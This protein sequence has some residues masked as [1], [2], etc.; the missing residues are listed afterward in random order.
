MTYPQDD[1]AMPADAGPGPERPGGPGRV[2][3]VLVG[4]LVLLL[5]TGACIWSITSARDTAVR[6]VE[7]RLNLIADGRVE[8]VGAW[9]DGVV[10]AAAR[11]ADSQFLRAYAA[12]RFGDDGDT[13]AGTPDTGGG[14]DADGPPRA[15]DGAAGRGARL[16]D[17]AAYLRNLARDFV[18]RTRFLRLVLVDPTGAPALSDAASLGDIPAA[19]AE[20]AVATAEI[21]FGASRVRD[22]TTI[23][24][25]AYPVVRPQSDRAPDAVVGA[26]LLEIGL[27][28]ILRDATRLPDL[29][30]GTETIRVLEHAGG[31]RRVLTP[32]GH[33]AW[34]VAGVGD[35]RAFA[36]T[37]ATH[38]GTPVFAAG[39]P[40]DGLPWSV[41][42]STTVDRALSDWRRFSW[43]AA[44]VAAGLALAV[45]GGLAGFWYRLSASHARDR[46]AREQAF[47]RRIERERRLLDQITGTVPELIALKAGDGSYRYVNR[48][49]ARLSGRPKKRLVGADDA[50]VF[51]PTLAGRLARL[52]RDA[53]QRD[54]E[55]TTLDQVYRQGEVRHVRFSAQPF[56]EP[57]SAAG[58]VL[59][60]GTDLTEILRAEEERR[61]ELE[62]SVQAL[63]R[64]VET[65]DPYLAGHSRRMERLGTAVARDLRLSESEVTT[66]S[67]AA[68]LSQ[69]G[70][71]GV[72]RELLTSAD[73]HSAEEIREMQT[74]IDH[75]DRILSE[76]Q[77]ELPV[78]ET[79][80]QMHERLDGS[81]YPEGLSGAAIRTTA[82]VLGAVDVFCARLEPRSYR[83][84]IDRA[85]ALGVLGDHPERY[86]AE[87]V[88]ALQRVVASPEGDK[89]LADLAG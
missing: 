21:T 29:A 44:A 9:R 75:A 22:G 65:V 12:D 74:H 73:R 23:V 1:S 57:D 83:P 6:S 72:R 71:L 25:V 17:R 47:A 63:G 36:F 4:G 82:R 24:P 26:V 35:D 69:V 68:R 46:A 61:A 55:V 76:I 43:A 49:L 89:A 37:Q 15:D 2:G 62:R 48:A 31:D 60:V 41:V 10:R 87:V 70:K 50:A 19:L 79:V 34:P 64:A 81:G 30:R 28:T 67:L 45:L 86:D 5:V 38:D 84:P 77:F 42:V 11:F 54:G 32:D 7:S 85:E 39:Q 78:R 3:F 58:S 33:G 40:V 66:V 59:M 53:A 20:R 8:L 56:A 52:D 27:R 13:A 80:V 16:D 88:A 14:P 51:G 18:E